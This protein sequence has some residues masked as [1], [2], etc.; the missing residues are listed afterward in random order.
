MTPEPRP[1]PWRRI[2]IAAALLVCTSTAPAH[3]LRILNWNILNFPGSAPSSRYSAYQQ[4]IG[5]IGP[6]LMVAEE[7][8]STSNGSGPTLFLNNVLNGLE[9]GQWDR[10]PFINGNDTDANLFFKPAKFQFLGQ[11]AFYMD[12]PILRYC[13]VYRIR[14]V[15]YSSEATEIRLYVVHLKASMGFETQRGTE[16]AVLRDSMNASPPGTHC[17]TMGDFNVYNKTSVEPAILRMTESQAN[18]NGQCYDPLGLASIVP[19]QDNPSIAVFHTQSPC[20]S[21]TCAP[22]AATGGL[23]DRFDLILPTLNWNDGQAYELMPGSYVSVGNDGQHLNK[24]ITDAPTIPEGASFAAALKAASDHLPVRVD[25]QVPAIA[26]VP[27]ELAIGTVIGD[28]TKDLSV[29]NVAVAP[30]DGLSYTLTASPGFTAPAG[31][32]E[33]PVGTTQQHAIGLSPD[34]PFGPR[35]GSVTVTSDDLDHPVRI[36][37]VTANVLDHAHASLDSLV[38][39]TAGSIDFGTQTSGGFT[40]Q[41]VAVHD[42]GYSSLQ[43]RLSVTNGTIAGGDGHFSIVGGFNPA[44]VADVGQRYDVAFDDTGATQD[45]TYT[46]TLTFESSDEALPGAQAATPLTVSLSA[47]VAGGTADTPREAPPTATRLYTPYPNPLSGT[48]RIQLDLARGGHVMLDVIDLAGRNVARLVDRDLD[49]GRHAFS[50]SGQGSAG[51]RV[52]AG[53]YFVRVSGLGLD[54]QTVRLAV[55]R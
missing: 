52:P 43:A 19:W 24:N 6:D 38:E 18:N 49:A 16:A 1:L 23:D 20:S 2:G 15:G 11:W 3:A 17:F 26:D 51:A 9:P 39:Q 45:S 8:D 31:S 30:A 13:H 25:I 36:V 55:M 33:A 41:T 32:F 7:I 48:S 22:G 28:G 34:P 29:S 47:R 40:A 53:V 37:S 42:F 27:S 44:L 54:A 10:S 35:S 50:W 46:A 14:P 5:F 12:S 21:G 4:I